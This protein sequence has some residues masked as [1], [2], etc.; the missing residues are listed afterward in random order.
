MTCD[1]SSRI[2][3]HWYTLVIFYSQLG[4]LRCGVKIVYISKRK[5]SH[6]IIAIRLAKRRRRKVQAGTSSLMNP[7]EWAKAQTPQFELW[8]DQDSIACP[9]VLS[10]TCACILYW[11]E[12][13]ASANTTPPAMETRAQYQFCEW[14]SWDRVAIR[15][16][17]LSNT[18]MPFFDDDS[19]PHMLLKPKSK[20]KESFT[21]F[22]NTQYCVL[23]S[24]L[25]S[26]RLI[27]LLAIIAVRISNE[28]LFTFDVF[29]C[30]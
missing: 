21:V 12:R 29:Y 7:Q 10:H 30:K 4:H 17:R 28:K 20:V 8:A 23:G 6:I 25:S 1:S 3:F 18:N 9:T 26:K 14:R 16:S 11:K 15:Q 2:W 13:T 19:M 27:R 24:L 5:L 22:K